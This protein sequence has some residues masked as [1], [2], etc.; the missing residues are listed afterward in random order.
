V[1]DNFTYEAC[2]ECFFTAGLGHETGCKNW[3]DEPVTLTI[4]RA[5][6]EHM[7]WLVELNHGAWS[8]QYEVLRP[9]LTNP[10]VNPAECV[11]CG[12]PVRMGHYADCPYRTDF[13]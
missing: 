5:V 3:P 4:P 11:K 2:P 8:Q 1:S 6:L 9:Y 12:W 7:A 10:S 13:S